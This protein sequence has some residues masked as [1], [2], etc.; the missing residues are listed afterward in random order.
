M[1]YGKQR[2]KVTKDGSDVVDELTTAQ[3]EANT[4]ML[5]VTI[6]SCLL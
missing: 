4:H 2:F 6:D 3:D 5:P 1:T